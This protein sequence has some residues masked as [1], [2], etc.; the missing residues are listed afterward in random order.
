M[1]PYIDPIYSYEL[2]LDHFHPGRFV[3]ASPIGQF[4]ELFSLHL[5]MQD[6]I[7]GN[8]V[9]AETTVPRARRVN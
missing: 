9:S 8:A 7:T 2:E 3:P 4:S 5:L 1:C 6:R